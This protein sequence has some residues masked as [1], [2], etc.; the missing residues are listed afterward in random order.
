M[1]LALG[2]EHFAGGCVA[3]FA[4]QRQYFSVSCHY[5]ET[6][7]NRISYRMT[8]KLYSSLLMTLLLGCNQHKTQPTDTFVVPKNTLPVYKSVGNQPPPLMKG[9]YY[10]SNFIVDTGGHIY[11]YQ[12]KV[13]TGWICGTGLEWDTPPLFIDLTP[14]D[15]I[16][17]P[18]DNLEEFIKMNVN[19]VDTFDR[20]VSIA[21]TVDTIKSAGLATIFK[22]FE[23]RNNHIINWVF[24]R[25]TQEE[26]VVLDYKKRQIPYNASA[27]KW[28]STKT[29]FPTPPP[30]LLTN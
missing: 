15:M 19:Y 10:P 8:I 24:R 21:S 20:K 6:V 7:F 16:Q 5:V 25:M 18:I 17:V 30:K 1:T 14:K 22:T 29:L 4:A 26:N 23:D 9:Y 13:L 2:G 27:I 11:Y 28:D 3:Y 12:Q